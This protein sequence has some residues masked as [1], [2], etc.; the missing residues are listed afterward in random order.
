MEAQTIEKQE[1]SIGKALWHQ[2]TT[3]VILWENMRYKACT[4]EDIVFYVVELLEEDQMIQSLH[5]RGSEMSL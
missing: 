1:A 3:V 4:S 2:V 5:K